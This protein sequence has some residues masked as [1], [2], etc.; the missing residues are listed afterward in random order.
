MV[1]YI[2]SSVLFI[3]FLD[4]ENQDGYGSSPVKSLNTGDH[5]SYSD[6]S[7]L[8]MLM[9]CVLLTGFVFTYSVGHTNK[10]RSVFTGF[11]FLPCPDPP[12]LLPFPLP[13]PVLPQPACSAAF[14]PHFLSL[15]LGAGWGQTWHS[16][17]QEDRLQR[18][19]KETCNA[20]VG[21]RGAGEE[22]EDD[23]WP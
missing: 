3:S 16:G 1:P 12:T 19:L 8:T 23:P 6:S 13:G 11:M 2:L 17:K 22:G 18:A 9:F 4:A 20:A 14:S 10:P 21:C 15:Q 7:L 5:M